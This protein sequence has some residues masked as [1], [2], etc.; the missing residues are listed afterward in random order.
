VSEEQLFNGPG[1]VTDPL[2]L[3]RLEKLAQPTATIH[4]STVRK[5]EESDSAASILFLFFTRRLP[6][7]LL[8]LPSLSLRSCTRKDEVGNGCLCS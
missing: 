8:L 4:F 7:Y 1:R 5:R 3:A 6:V 2:Q